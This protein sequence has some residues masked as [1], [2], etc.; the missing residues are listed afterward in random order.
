MFVLTLFSVTMIVN[1]P[2]CL[3]AHKLV[4]C[5]H[6]LGVSLIVKNKIAFFFPGK[7]DE[8][9]DHPAKKNEEQSQK[10]KRPVFP[11][12][13]ESGVLKIWTQAEDVKEEWGA[14]RGFP[15]AV[16]GQEAERGLSGAV[17][18]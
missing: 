13:P 14:E 1:Q 15:G 4:R 8:L 5:T 2:Q 10:D 9:G 11:Q 7:M 6:S 18:R 3:S 12:Y 16:G 17:G